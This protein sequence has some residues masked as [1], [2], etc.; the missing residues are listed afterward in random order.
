MKFIKLYEGLNVVEI[1]KY[2][3][4]TKLQNG[5]ANKGKIQFGMRE[6]IYENFH[7]HSMLY[8]CVKIL[9]TDYEKDPRIREIE[10]EP[11]SKKVQLS[12]KEVVIETFL[13]RVGYDI[14]TARK[15][16][17]GLPFLTMYLHTLDVI[18]M[19]S[20]TIGDILDGLKQFETQ[21]KKYEKKSFDKWELKKAMNKYNL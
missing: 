9:D 10:L 14:D 2:L 11:N 3:K 20:N 7:P 16:I 4:I 6:S 12:S 15:K 1:D 19:N 13:V 21:V 5:V 8:G 18:V 17:H